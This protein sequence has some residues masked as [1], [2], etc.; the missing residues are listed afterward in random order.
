MLVVFS[1]RS[2]IMMY[3]LDNLKRERNFDLEIWIWLKV[4]NLNFEIFNRI[5]ILI[6]IEYEAF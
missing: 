2:F 1:E 6:I 4:K 3:I 5:I